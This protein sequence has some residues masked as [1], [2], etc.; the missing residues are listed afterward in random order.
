MNVNYL[1]TI[2]GQTNEVLVFITTPRNQ[3]AIDGN[4]VQFQCSACSTLQPK[5]KWTFTRKGSEQSEEVDENST[6]AGAVSLVP[7]ENS[8]SLAI[9]SVDSTYEGVYKCMISTESNMIQ[10]AASLNVLSK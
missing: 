7:G 1:M 2:T 8:L 6:F 3:T 5:I 4:S 9:N 10:A